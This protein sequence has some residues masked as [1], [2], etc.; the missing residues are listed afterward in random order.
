MPNFNPKAWI[1]SATAFT[2]EGNFEAEATR[3]PL[4]ERPEDQQSSRIMYR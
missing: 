1:R 4:S 2:P 3:V